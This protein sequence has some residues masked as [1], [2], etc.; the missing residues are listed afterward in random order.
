MFCIDGSFTS[1]VKIID[2]MVNFF[3]TSQRQRKGR[4]Q[5][6]DGNTNQ[7]VSLILTSHF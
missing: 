3:S 2:I 1:A 6:A 7:K 4:M 5:A